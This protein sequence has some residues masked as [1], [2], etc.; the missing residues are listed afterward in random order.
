MCRQNAKP[1]RCYVAML[2]K[3]Q[4]NTR[5]EMTTPPPSS[6]LLYNALPLA[7]GHSQNELTNNK[8]DNG[9]SG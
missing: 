1:M 5:P 3:S 7:C 8:D 9:R 6:Q 4:A 2:M